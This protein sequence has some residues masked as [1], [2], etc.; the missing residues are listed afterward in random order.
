[1]SS[2]QIIA[3]IWLLPS[4]AVATLILLAWA[5]AGGTLH[6]GRTRRG[7]RRLEHYANQPHHPRYSRTPARKEKP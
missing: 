7:I 5:G 1:M 6:P 3:A 2:L 4:T